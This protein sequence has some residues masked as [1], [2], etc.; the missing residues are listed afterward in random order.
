MKEIIEILR[1]ELILC[2]EIDKLFAEMKN[3][4]QEQTSG[5]GVS[6]ATHKLEGLMARLGQLEKRGLEKLAALGQPSMAVYLAAE[7]DSPAQSMAL[8]LCGRVEE[9]L[10]R[11]KNELAENQELLNRA[12]K[13]IDFN[14]NV[15]TQTAADSTYA[16][17]KRTAGAGQRGLKMFDQSV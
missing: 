8:T 9:A 17:P 13:F 12:K 7:P 11:L 10:Q 6:E 5:S 3:I 4:L 14:I 16:P 15:M 1:Q 2:G